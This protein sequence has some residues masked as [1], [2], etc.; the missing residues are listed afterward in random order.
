MGGG[1]ELFLRTCTGKRI[2][3]GGKGGAQ[4]GTYVTTHGK[5]GTGNLK[6]LGGEGVKKRPGEYSLCNIVK[7]ERNG[8][9][10]KKRLF[11]GRLGRRNTF[12]VGLKSCCG[13]YGGKKK[14]GEKKRNGD[15]ST[16]GAQPKVF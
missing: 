13:L 15:T 16:I 5:S 10:P 1:T 4:P 14:R 7:K 11:E 2:K 8:Q 9:Y 3:G 6:V 12:P